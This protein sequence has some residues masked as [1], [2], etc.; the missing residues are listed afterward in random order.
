MGQAFFVTGTDTGA[1]KTHAT[2]ALL[3][4]ARRAG[5]T[6]L[7]MKP[8]AAGV[9]ADGRN[10][11]VSHLL[12]ASTFEPPLE[13]VNPFLYTPAIAPHIAAR[14]A[15]RPIEMAVIAQAFERLRTRAD[16]VWVE[17]VGG[18]R[19]PLDK[20]WDT[21]DLAQKLALPVVLVVGMRLGCLNHALL[22]AEAI[23]GRRLPLAGWIANRVDPAMERFEANLETLK[24]RLRAPLIGVTAYGIAPDLA[25]GALDLTVLP[26]LR[27]LVDPP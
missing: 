24:Q 1:G 8:I 26:G 9:G 19:V 14:E 18:F 7:A 22:T 16:T 13:W 6:A 3:H 5:L 21:A 27:D 10:E 2:C 23:T 11:D 12:A 15:G 17:G 20:R 4:A 25:A